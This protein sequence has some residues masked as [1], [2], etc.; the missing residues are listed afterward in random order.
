MP[1][2]LGLCNGLV[3]NLLMEIT[4]HTMRKPWVVLLFYRKIELRSNHLRFIAL[5]LI[6]TFVAFNL[7][8]SVTI[9]EKFTAIKPESQEMSRTIMAVINEAGGGGGGGG[10]VNAVVIVIPFDILFTHHSTNSL[11]H[12]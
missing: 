7:Q 8:I 1:W 5:T 12:L 10:G 6:L 11:I 3:V 2:C 4:L 9:T